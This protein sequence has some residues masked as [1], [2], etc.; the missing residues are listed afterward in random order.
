MS[1]HLQKR[2]PVLAAGRCMDTCVFG[3]FRVVALAGSMLRRCWVPQSLLWRVPPLVV[4]VS[5]CSLAWPF[6]C[7]W[8]WYVACSAVGS[9]LACW[10][11]GERGFRNPP[12]THP[13]IVPLPLLRGPSPPS[14][15]TGTCTTQTVLA[16]AP[17]P[18]LMYRR[19]PV[20]LSRSPLVPWGP[21]PSTLGTPP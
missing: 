14:N 2:A 10:P 21:P 11:A 15:R 9:V 8:V 18:W 6:P 1:P 3:L 19:P 17:T 20:H 16:T 13:P 7:L 5:S 12:G 4:H